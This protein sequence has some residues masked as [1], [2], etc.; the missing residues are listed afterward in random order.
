[1]RFN[2]PE[3]VAREYASEERFAAR[4]V[5]FSDFVVGEKA[6]DFALAA[7]AETQPGRILEIG[8][9]LGEL[10]ARMADELR[11]QVT[12]VD[13]SPRMVEMARARG[14]DGSIADAEALPFQ[15]GEFDAVVANWVFDHLPDLHRGLTEAERVLTDG[16]RLVAATFSADHLLELYEWLGDSSVGE[17]AFSSENGEEPLRAHF[18]RVERRDADGTV[19]FP[20]RQALHGYLRSLIHGRD[21]ADRLPEFDGEFRARSRQSIFVCDKT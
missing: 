2:D 5:A 6:E 17:L 15:D 12:A 14:V 11:A 9:G 7:L 20:D 1:V 19:V 8:C 21:L 3:L 4:R 16:G 10:A 13:L 18:A